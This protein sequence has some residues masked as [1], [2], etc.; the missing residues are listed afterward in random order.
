MRRASSEAERVREKEAGEVVVSV[1]WLA[2]VV[3]LLLLLRHRLTLVSLSLSVCFVHPA[4]HCYRGLAA[5]GGC[6]C[7]PPP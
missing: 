5:G 7:L 4:I 3:L 1:S 2:P 6:A